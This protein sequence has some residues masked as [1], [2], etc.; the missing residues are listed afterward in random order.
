MDHVALYNLIRD[1][2]NSG[3]WKHTWHIDISDFNMYP[4][5]LQIAEEKRDSAIRLLS[6]AFTLIEELKLC[7]KQIEERRATELAEQ[8]IVPAKRKIQIGEVFIT[9]DSYGKDG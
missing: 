9:G 4:R 2:L 7:I 6:D 3:E 1:V 5:I 8:T